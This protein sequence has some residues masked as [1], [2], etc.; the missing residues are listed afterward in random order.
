MLVENKRIQ[1]TQLLA[2]LIKQVFWLIFVFIKIDLEVIELEFDKTVV[3]YKNL[4]DFFFD[5][6]D[7][8]APHKTQYRSLILYTDE[9]QKD[10]ANKALEAVKVGIRRLKL[11]IIL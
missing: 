8:T 1:L 10:I 3:S 4:V 11:W 6:H 5:H 9:E 7:P 2:R